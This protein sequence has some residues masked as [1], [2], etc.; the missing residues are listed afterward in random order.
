VLISVGLQGFDGRSDPEKLGAAIIEL[1]SAEQPPLRY[2]AG[3][4]AVG[5]IQEGFTKRQYE[6]ESWRALSVSTD[7]AF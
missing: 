6:V 3:S 5:L 2:V 7:G 4:D 1:A